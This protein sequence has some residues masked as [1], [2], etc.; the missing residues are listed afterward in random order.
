MKMLV[1]HYEC[2]CVFSDYSDQHMIY[3]TDCRNIHEHHLVAPEVDSVCSG[4]EK[5]N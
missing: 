3:S 4:K 5:V 2:V 1:P